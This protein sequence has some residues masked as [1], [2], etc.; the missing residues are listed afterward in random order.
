MHLML[1]FYFKI[2]YL[3]IQLIFVNRKT[4][5]CIAVNKLRLKENE[6]KHNEVYSVRWDPHLPLLT[7]H[8]VHIPKMDTLPRADTLSRVALAFLVFSEWSIWI[9]EINTDYRCLIHVSQEQSIQSR[10]WLCK[11]LTLSWCEKPRSSLPF[12]Y[13]YLPWAV[14]CSKSCQMKNVEISQMW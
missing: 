2:C 14:P 7:L 4:G 10:F 1:I 12:L 8:N 5:R 3:F 13:V 11:I 9:T 6:L